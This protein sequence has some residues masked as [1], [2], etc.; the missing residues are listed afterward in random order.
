MVGKLKKQSVFISN[1]FMKQ[2][3]IIIERS[4]DLYSSY[5]ENVD[6]IYGAGDTVEEAK[7]SILDAIEIIK[8]I[9][10]PKNIPKILNGNYELTYKFDTQSF[11]THYLGIFTTAALERITGISQ[12]HISHYAT[13]LKKPRKTQIKK[14]QAALHSLGSE[15][16]SVEL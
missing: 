16:M 6:G 12:Q 5:A 7:Q 13:G 10:R 9:K 14:I 1:H 15:L 11:L 8:E 4:I 2:I 3:K